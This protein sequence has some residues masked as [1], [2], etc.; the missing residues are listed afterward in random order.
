MS[1]RPATR[2]E[3]RSAA[4]VLLLIA[5]GWL[6]VATMLLA[7]LEQ[8]LPPGLQVPRPALL[9]QP[10]ILVAGASLLGW[11]AAPKVG[12]EAA[13]IAH[14]CAHLVALP[15]LGTLG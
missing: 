15:L 12:L 4:F 7:P 9:I 5:I 8:M 1:D 10:A 6:G 13:M 11:W 2:I 3:R 14:A